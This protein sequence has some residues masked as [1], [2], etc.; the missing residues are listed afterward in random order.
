MLCCC[1]RRFISVSYIIQDRVFHLWP[2]RRF[3]DQMSQKI[4]R[5]CSKKKRREKFRY[6]DLNAFLKRLSKT[7]AIKSV[8]TSGRTNNFRTT[9]RTYS[10]LR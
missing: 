2:V 10:S 4:E 7:F 8:G 9:D 1:M 6:N 3:H 5:K